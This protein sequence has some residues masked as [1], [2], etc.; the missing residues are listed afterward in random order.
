VFNIFWQLC[1]FVK[2]SA[3]I[4]CYNKTFFEKRILIDDKGKNVKTKGEG[5]DWGK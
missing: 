3:K 2:S 1:N 5:G 4:I